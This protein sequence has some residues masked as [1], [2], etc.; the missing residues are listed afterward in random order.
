MNRREFYKELMQEYTFDTAKVRRYAKLSCL[1]GKS[2]NRTKLGKVG[3]LR[4]ITRSRSRRVWKVSATVA[5]AAVAL[6]VALQYVFFGGFFGDSMIPQSLEARI[7]HAKLSADE[8]A[9][10]SFGTRALFLS[11]ND[12]IDFVAMSNALDSVSDTGNIVV[13]S[14]YVLGENNEVLVISLE[15]ARTTGVDNIVGVKV[16]VP[17]TLVGQ[18]RQQSQIALVEVMDDALTQETFVPLAVAELIEL[19]GASTQSQTSAETDSP[20]TEVSDGNQVSPIGEN[21]EILE[22]STFVDFEVQGATRAKFISDSA[23]VVF[24]GDVIKVCEIVQIIDGDSNISLTSFTGIEDTNDSEPENTETTDDS[25]EYGDGTEGVGM[26]VQT[27]R[28]EVRAS[29]LLEGDLLFTFFDNVNDRLVIRSRSA[30]YNMIHIL[31]F[32]TLDFSE[33]VNTASE[34]SVLA[35]TER[36]IYY[37]IGRMVINR[38]SVGH[39]ESMKVQ[40]LSFERPVSFERNSVLSGFVIFTGDDSPAQVFDANTETLASSEDVLGGLLYYKNSSNVLTDGENFF[41]THLEIIDDIYNTTLSLPRE[42]SG[43]ASFIIH[44][45]TDSRVRISARN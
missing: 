34:L 41:N 10:L 28:V 7:D 36:Y 25:V 39:G 19:E 2:S 32:G 45:I 24:T 43:S 31:D 44:S 16:S 42:S 29:L 37:S 3:S 5:A 35:S 6:V 18:L 22:T 15:E 26:L 11:F 9:S 12:G 8:V 21:D 13:E 40:G 14:V 33:V 4:D 27:K 38:Y 17:V 23:F 1:D 20:A 30:N